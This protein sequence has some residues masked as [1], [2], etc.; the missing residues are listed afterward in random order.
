MEHSPRIAGR[1]TKWFSH[2]GIQFGG[3]C[4]KRILLREKRL[5]QTRMDSYPGYIKNSNKLIRQA[6]Q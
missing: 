3:F 4:V 1:T 5:S 2:F 6:T